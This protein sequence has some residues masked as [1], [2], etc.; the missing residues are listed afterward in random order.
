MQ[1]IGGRFRVVPDRHDPAA[2]HWLAPTVLDE[3]ALPGS[4]LTGSDPSG[5]IPSR[6]ATH[7]AVSPW[8][9]ED[10]GAG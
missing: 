2:D 1:R 10:A 8:W 4:A 5:V 6:T 3:V 9:R 7:A